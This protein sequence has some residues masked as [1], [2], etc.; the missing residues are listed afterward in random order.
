MA[1][2]NLLLSVQTVDS[3]ILSLLKKLFDPTP[4]PAPQSPYSS[5]SQTGFSSFWL[6]AA[7]I[8]DGFDR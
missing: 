5:V 6:F 4:S 8:F 7:I 2:L 3:V 1:T